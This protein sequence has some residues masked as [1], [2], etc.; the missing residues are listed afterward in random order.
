[1]DRLQPPERWIGGSGSGRLVLGSTRSS[2]ASSAEA[3]GKALLTTAHELMTNADH[4]LRRT[5]R[6]QPFTTPAML[7]EDPTEGARQVYF[8]RVAESER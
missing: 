6:A 7:Q 3:L 8:D 2:A 4:P 5:R 1:M